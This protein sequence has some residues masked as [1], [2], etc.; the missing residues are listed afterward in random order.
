MA[1]WS[2]LQTRMQNGWD[3]A[4]PFALYRHWLW[5]A[6]VCGLDTGADITIGSLPGILG[7]FYTAGLVDLV[8]TEAYDI[9]LGMILTETTLEVCNG[10]A[11]ESI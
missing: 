5:I 10:G 4:D 9:P 8:P 2:L 6:G 3:A 11:S 1:S 7:L